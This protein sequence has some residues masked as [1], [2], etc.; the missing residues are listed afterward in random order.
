MSLRNLESVSSEF[1][2]FACTPVKH[3]IPETNGV[4]YN[5]IAS[6]HQNDLEFLILAD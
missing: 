4:V 3:A 5:P 1:D 6:I 2:V